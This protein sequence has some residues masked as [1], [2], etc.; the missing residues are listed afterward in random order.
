[1]S[2]DDIDVIGMRAELVALTHTRVLVALQ[3]ENVRGKGSPDTTRDEIKLLSSVLS[4]YRD[5]LTK[6]GISDPPPAATVENPEQA[7]GVV[8]ERPRTL[9][10]TLGIEEGAL[11]RQARETAAGL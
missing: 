3:R 7:E 10:E 8:R 6:L 1:M 2:A 9:A 4:D 5:D 11:L